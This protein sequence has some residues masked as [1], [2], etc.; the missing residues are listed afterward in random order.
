VDVRVVGKW[1]GILV[2][3]KAGLCIGVYLGRRIQDCD[4]PF[5]GSKIQDVRRPSLHNRI[6]T[7]I[8]FD[9]LYAALLTIG[10]FSPIALLL[11]YFLFPP[12]ALLG[13][14]GCAAAIHV[15]YLSLEGR[16]LIRL[17]MAILGINQIVWGLV[18]VLY[19]LRELLRSA[20]A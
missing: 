18:I 10:V 4:L 16:A 17:P 12:L 14:V 9:L 19:W 3:N 6:L 11:G 2:I 5:E 7:A 1:D 20:I 15:T 8:P 13:V